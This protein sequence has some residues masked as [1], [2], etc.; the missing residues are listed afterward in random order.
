MHKILFLICVIILSCDNPVRSPA[1]VEYKTGTIKPVSFYYLSGMRIIPTDYTDNGDGAYVGS[2]T[3]KMFGVNDFTYEVQG[4][5]SGNWSVLSLTLDNNEHVL[6]YRSKY[7]LF[8]AVNM[9][10]KRI[11]IRN[12][13]IRTFTDIRANIISERFS[14]VDNETGKEYTGLLFGFVKLD[15]WEK[16]GVTFKEHVLYDDEYTTKNG[17]KIRIERSAISQPYIWKDPY[18]VKVT[19]TK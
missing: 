14:F 2:I 15:A 11:V 18:R 3:K 5:S 1:Y 8:E 9:I 13:D 7:Y 10:Y 19:F 6:H 4:D 17:I 16:N 12:T